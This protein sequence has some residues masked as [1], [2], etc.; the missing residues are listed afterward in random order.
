MEKRLKPNSVDL[1]LTSP[2]Y[3]TNK[4]AGKSRT[5]ENTSV[6]DGQYDYVRYDSFVDNY[7]EDEYND[8]TV[9]LFRGFDRVLIHDGCVLYNIN[10]GAENTEGMFRAVYAVIENTP[11]T[12]AD[13]IGWKKRTAI[14]NSTS[15][16]RL[17]R[18]WEFVFVFCRRKEFKTFKCNKKITS[19][20]KTGQAA[21]ENI[22]NYI[23]AKNNDG[24]CELNK[25]T[26]STE[27][28][29]KLLAIYATD[30][31]TT[32]Y[33]PFM[34]TGTTAV[35]C[36]KLGYDCY[37]SELSAKQVAYAYKR[38]NSDWLDDLLAR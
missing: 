22:P 3:N 9:K 19:H 16:N 30:S 15:K 6:K 34:G 14:P 32:V 11:F 5:L 23:E 38:L 20:R 13:V 17:T 7:T 28:V 4:K 1:I 21:Y 25:A 8:F 24:A 33:D 31:K 10:Y 26:F 37:G 18:I 35:S 2:F 27:L 36:Q 29:D 12:I